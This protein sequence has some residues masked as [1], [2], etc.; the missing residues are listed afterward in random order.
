LI[1]ET[2]KNHYEEEG[3]WRVGL[4]AYYTGKQVRRDFTPTDDYWI[5]GLMVLRKFKNISL[6]ANFENFTDTRQSRLEDI[7]L[8]TEMNPEQLDIWAPLEGFV[9]NAGIIIDF[10]HSGHH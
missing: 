1:L 2:L 4:E 3:K 8:S 5:A 6:Y 7:N 9:V 10:G